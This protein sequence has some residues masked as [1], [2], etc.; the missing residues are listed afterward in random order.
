MKWSVEELRTHITNTTHGKIVAEHDE[1]GHHYRL[2]DYDKKLVDSVTTKMIL[3]KPFLRA[4][5]TRQ[6]L[7][8]L[9][10][11]GRIYDVTEANMKSV[12]DRALNEADFVV[13]DASCIG[14]EA[15]EVADRYLR[16]WILKGEKPDSIRDFIRTEKLKDRYTGFEYSANDPRIYALARNIEAAIAARPVVPLASEIRVGSLTYDSAGT[17]D[18]IML[19]TETNSIELWD[20]KS[21]NYMYDTYAMQASVYADMFQ[22]MTGL[23]VG[24][25][26]VVQAD[27]IKNKH[28]FYRVIDR[29][30][31]TATFKHLSLVYNWVS[32][33]SLKYEEIGKKIVSLTFDDD[34]NE[35]Y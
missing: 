3:D 22:E 5:H 12:F 7:R 1:K 30:G 16:S 15:H 14:T 19:N 20:W 29:E 35:D 13:S 18:A 21:S 26:F 27:K 8:W 31:A 2:I 23:E 6:A 25:C 33:D 9:G 4:W 32:S 24:E 11:D 28:T 10:E 17:V 34:E